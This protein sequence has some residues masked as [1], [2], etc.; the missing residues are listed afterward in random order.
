MCEREVRTKKTL[1]FYVLWF[2]CLSLHIN[3]NKLLFA[4]KQDRYNGLDVLVV[5]KNTTLDIEVIDEL[6]KKSLKIIFLL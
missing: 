2:K 5:H 6:V 4:I 3:K 1:T